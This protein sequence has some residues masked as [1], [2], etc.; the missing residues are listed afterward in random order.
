MSEQS[1]YAAVWEHAV[2]RHVSPGAWAVP[3]FLEVANPRKGETLRDL[4]CGTGRAGVALADVGLE[5]T[6]YDLVP[7]CR[8]EEAQSLPFVQHDLTQPI[9]G[10]ADYAYCCDVLE[11]IA[12][13]DVPRV[14]RNVVTAGRRAFLQ[15]SCVPDHMGALIGEPLH[16]TVENAAWWQAQLEAFDCRVIWSE[17][18]GEQC[19]FYV[20]AYADAVD[21]GPKTVLNVSH[22][23]I[24]ANVRANLAADYAEVAPHTT[25]DA[26][27]LVLAGGP[28]LADHEDEIIARR[29]AGEPLVTVNGSYNWAVERGLAPSIQMLCDAREFNR[30]FVEPVVPRCRYLIAS[31]CHPSIAASLPREQVLLW[32]SGDHLRET[33]AG[34]DRE[35]GRERQWYPVFG[36]GT[37]ILRGLPLLM[38]L[39]FRRFELYGFDSCLRADRH[40]A[41]AQ[42]ENDRRTEI[43]VRVGGREFLC[44]PWMVAQAGDF[45]RLQ[46]FIAPHIDLCVHGDG[47]IAH[48]IE[49]AALEE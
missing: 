4:G 33:I 31:Q 18:K 24:T 48:I 35:T 5:V 11:H 42:P 25:Q 46:K 26:T 14:L 7:N 38:M 39:G 16:L 36:G 12:T 41:Y 13:E 3:Q 22:D 30:R 2:Y 10:L 6:Q 44:H 19:S 49:T 20:S 43:P 9:A 17:D 37:V 45:L 40:H 1:K 27:L 23:T 21:Y 29:K 32:H 47:L 8:D 28:S 15:I 34:F